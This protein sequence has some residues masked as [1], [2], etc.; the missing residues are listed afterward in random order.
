MQKFPIIIS[1]L[2]AVLLSCYIYFFEM[3]TEA[4][5]F[6]FSKFIMTFEPDDVK[7]IE[8]KNKNSP[9]INFSRNSK[10]WRITKPINC[11]ANQELIESIINQLPKLPKIYSVPPKDQKPLIDYGLDKPL[12][13]VSVTYRD[14]NKGK[15]KIRTLSFGLLTGSKN[16]VFAKANEDDHIYLLPASVYNVLSH[17]F[18]HYR[19]K[20]LL[21]QIPENIIK[22][23][24][25]TPDEK[26]TISKADFI[27]KVTEPYSWKA[28][29]ETVVE[30][31]KNLS[32]I[33]I[34]RFVENDLSKKENYGLNQPVIK[35]QYFDIDKNST[36]IYVGASRAGATFIQNTKE[37]FIY[38]VDTKELLKC[39][40]YLQSLKDYSLFTTKSPEIIQV[41]YSFENINFNFQKNIKQLWMVN[42]SVYPLDQ[43]VV[44]AFA[45]QIALTSP[46]YFIDG[47]LNKEEFGFNSPLAITLNIINLKNQKETI[48]IGS[49]AKGWVISSALM[50][51]SS[52]EKAKKYA[53]QLKIKDEEISE[54]KDQYFA[55]YQNLT[56]I[57]TI[58]EL[59]VNKLKWPLIKFEPLE[60]AEIDLNSIFT[61]DRVINGQ[62][63]HYQ[64]FGSN[65]NWE[66]IS[67]EKA[68]LNDKEI[69]LFIFSICFF[70]V[71]EWIKGNFKAEEFK[72]YGLDNP[73]IQLEATFNDISEA[74]KTG[75][76]KFVISKKINGKYY[77]C[78]Y[79]SINKQDY[80]L[81]PKLFT[82]PEKTLLE[83]FM[84]KLY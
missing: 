64:R 56:Q 47:E 19:Y 43:Q 48:K 9:Q 75:K 8:I 70:K 81:I 55:T 73:L 82:V 21:D 13:V 71:E 10:V 33:E 52:L 62:K 16:E 37:N 60:F 1:L 77:G 44:T 63:E 42:N 12:A 46:E 38:S 67:P 34:T 39:I 5:A 30:L 65:V 68:K 24:Y 74:I 31:L 27:W 54:L 7:E 69:A 2:I 50:Y 78:Y 45:E 28:N 76:Y 25:D 3:Q 61:I 57:F 49:K 53:Q 51:F 66:I 32:G 40:P 72:D 41:D 84:K 17:D 11:R 6:T 18:N 26:W 35:I 20:K 29:Q 79:L 80:I 15:D 4:E 83:R 23:I 22:V 36:I 14:P 58:D 59:I